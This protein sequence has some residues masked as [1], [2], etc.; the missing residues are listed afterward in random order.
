MTR[1]EW[2]FEVQWNIYVQYMYSTMLCIKNQRQQAK[3]NEKKISNKWYYSCRNEIFT[4][5]HATHL[6]ISKNAYTFLQDIVCSCQGDFQI[7]MK[8]IRYLLVSHPCVHMQYSIHWSVNYVENAKKLDASPYLRCSYKF[9][10]RR[11]NKQYGN[12]IRIP[13]KIKDSVSFDFVRQTPI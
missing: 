4:H 3:E 6:D 11:E 13:T 2:A 7:F 10:S 1:K 5:N 12:F 9:S 8:A